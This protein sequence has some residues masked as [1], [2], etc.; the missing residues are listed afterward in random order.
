MIRARRRA[1]DTGR[2]KVVQMLRVSILT[3]KSKIAPRG[4]SSI[5]HGFDVSELTNNI[6]EI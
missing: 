2:E 5:A 6:G 3:V 4:F 1:E